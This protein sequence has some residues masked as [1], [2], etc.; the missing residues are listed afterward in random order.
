LSYGV[1]NRKPVEILSIRFERKTFDENG[2]CDLRLTREERKRMY[3]YIFETQNLPL[4][5]ALEYPNK[6]EIITIKNYLNSKYPALLKNDPLAIEY[7]IIDSK[8]LFKEQVRN[9]K[10]SHQQKCDK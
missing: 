9:F 10:K 3:E 5:K 4:P 7:A 8:E 6:T 1:K 2:A